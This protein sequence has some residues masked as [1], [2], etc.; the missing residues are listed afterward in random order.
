MSYTLTNELVAEL[1][2]QAV[3]ITVNGSPV[4]TGGV[5]NIGSTI[6]LTAVRGTFTSVSFY[7]PI[8][9]LVYD[10]VLSVGDSVATI[11]VPSGSYLSFSYS[12]TLVSIVFTFTSADV[13]SWLASNFNMYLN[14][15]LVPSADGFIALGD[16][17]KLVSLNSYVFDYARL[18][19]PITDVQNEF[20]L[21]NN[22]TNATL[23]ASEGYSSFTYST[24]NVVPVNVLGSNNV[25]SVADADVGTITSKRFVQQGTLG[26]VADYGNFILGLIRLPFAIDPVLVVGTEVVKV[27]PVSTGVSAGLLSTDRIKYSL[28]SIVVASTNSAL[29]FTEV[30]AE[31]HLPFTNPIKLD[32][33]YV[34]GQTI[35]VELAINLYNGDADYNISSTKLNGVVVTSKVKLDIAIPFSNVDG[36]PNINSPSNIDMG[37]D[38]GVKTAYIELIRKKPVLSNGFFTTPVSAEGLLS[39]QTGYVVVE[40]IQLKVPA[41]SYECELIISALKGGV[42]IT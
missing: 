38:N 37:L 35:S 27:G 21:S 30:E 16:V 18:Y 4:V 28:G 2:N 20:T 34:V 15:V 33:D 32:V 25:Y 1:R 12:G 17:V 40:D 31:L 5:V 10:A 6:E 22:N 26:N 9:D 19:S 39:A 14:D 13:D 41:T 24:T 42:I 3:S 29:D 8:E 36:V 7:D 23:T 11:D